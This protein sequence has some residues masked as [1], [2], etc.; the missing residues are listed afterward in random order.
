VPVIQH[1]KYALLS[2][3]QLINDSEQNIQSSS[4][5]TQ[6]FES[7]LFPQV[8]TEKQRVRE[9]EIQNQLGVAQA[10]I[11]ALEEVSPNAR[12]EPTRDQEMHDLRDQIRIL[13]GQ[14]QELS[15]RRASE[16]AQ[17]LMDVAPPVY[18]PPSRPHA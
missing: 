6:H 14:M 15:R 10:E 4:T 7:A 13:S 17:G 2:L 1:L 16:S 8:A 12:G 9:H 11:R 3:S 5:S 18:T